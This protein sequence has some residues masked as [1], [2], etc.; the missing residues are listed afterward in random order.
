MNKI[1]KAKTTYSLQILNQNY[2]HHIM[3]FVSKAPVESEEGHSA[4]GDKPAS[5]S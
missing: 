1:V 4:G 3:K 2:Y 5:G